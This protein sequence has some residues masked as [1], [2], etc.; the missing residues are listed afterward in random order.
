[1]EENKYFKETLKNFTFEHAAGGA[2]RHLA[3]LWY[4]TDRIAAELSF[5]T[6][7]ESIAKTVYG[8]YFDIGLLSYDPAPI[9]QKKRTVYEKK[10]SALGRT[11]FI[12]RELP[13]E[14]TETSDTEAKEAYAPFSVGLL[15]YRS[16][17]AYERFLQSLTAEDQ[18][19]VS[20]LPWEK[21]PVFLKVTERTR[22]MIK[23][24][25]LITEEDSGL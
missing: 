9:P 20:P 7:R 22:G 16:P 24:Y 14:E 1:M 3:D 21:K 4:S 23:A 25:R 2:I 15:K 18:A 13:L 6:P 11:S 19:L 10:Q 5:P 17:A 8:H 12:K